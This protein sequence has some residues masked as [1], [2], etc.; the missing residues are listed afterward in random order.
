MPYDF[1]FLAATE[2]IVVQITLLDHDVNFSSLSVCL[3]FIVLSL[4]FIV[5]R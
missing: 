3:F 5:H 1:F 4:P 2:I